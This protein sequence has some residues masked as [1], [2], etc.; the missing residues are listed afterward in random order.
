M[1]GL[2]RAASMSWS[3]PPLNLWPESPPPSGARGLILGGVV[4]LALLLISGGGWLLLH[5]RLGAVEAELQQ[6]QADSGRLELL[7]KRITAARVRSHA[8]VQSNQAVAQALVAVSSGSALLTQVMEDTPAG[9]Q[10][11]QLNTTESALSIKAAVADPEA[12]RRMNAMKVLLSRAAMIKP[13]SVVVSK[14]SRGEGAESG[15]LLMELQAA[16]QPIP[17]AEQRAV[18]QRLGAEGL[19][20]RLLILQRLKLL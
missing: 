5:W 12:F 8:M 13:A 18:L 11:R 3:V 9:V 1:F 14:V 6:L 20:R 15:L 16:F 19:A 17:A 10:L 2:W 4:G 7:Q